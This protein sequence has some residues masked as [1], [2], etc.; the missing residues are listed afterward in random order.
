MNGFFTDNQTKQKA[1]DRYYNAMAK[2][3]F[4][5]GRK[6]KALIQKESLDE[7][8]ADSLANLFQQVMAKTREYDYDQITQKLKKGAPEVVKGESS[9]TK[10]AAKVKMPSKKNNKPKV[11]YVPEVTDPDVT[12]TTPPSRKSSSEKNFEREMSDDNMVSPPR[13]AE[14]PFELP[15]RPPVRMNIKRKDFSEEEKEMDSDAD[16]YF[17]ALFGTD[18]ITRVDTDTVNKKI[19]KNGDD[20]ALNDEIFKIGEETVVEESK[21][22]GKTNRKIKKNKQ[23][24]KASIKEKVGKVMISKRFNYLDKAEKKAVAEEMVEQAVEYAKSELGKR[25]RQMTPPNK[26]PS[27]KRMTKK[28]MKEMK[29]LNLNDAYNADDDSAGDDSFDAEIEEELKEREYNKKRREE[30]MLVI[31]KESKP[32]TL[33]NKIRVQFG[34]EISEILAKRAGKTNPPKN[35]PYAYFNKEFPK[36]DKGRNAEK[37]K[38]NIEGQ[39]NAIYLY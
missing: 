15:F 35:E 12:M 32:L 11:K 21:S 39:I 26:S 5:Q 17:D 20:E 13:T 10:K 31:N 19:E 27:D 30:A 38:K 33:Y 34:K 9:Q 36:P 7:A 14:D 8:S 23:S 6:L 29:P 1:Y 2:S 4:M 3:D 22:K 25:K 28:A 37:Y 16:N 18:S 24:M